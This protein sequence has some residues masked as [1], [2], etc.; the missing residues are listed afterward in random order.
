MLVSRSCV[1]EAARPSLKGLED[2]SIGAQTQSGKQLHP[3]SSSVARQE[4]VEKRALKK[5]IRL[6]T[7]N[8]TKGVLPRENGRKMRLFTALHFSVSNIIEFPAQARAR[9][10][11]CLQSR[12]NDAIQ[13]QF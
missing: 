7:L 4:A 12:V 13:P 5:N 3:R 8:I 2:M 6:I 10:S 11:E 1:I 9:T